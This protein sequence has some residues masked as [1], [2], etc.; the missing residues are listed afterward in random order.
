MD[1]IM[2]LSPIF[3]MKLLSKRRGRKMAQGT[4]AS[5][6]IRTNV[7]DLLHQGCLRIE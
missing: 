3:C 1:A 5:K 4:A 7:R 2:F 6:K